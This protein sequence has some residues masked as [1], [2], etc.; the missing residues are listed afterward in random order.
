MNK[1]YHTPGVIAMHPPACLCIKRICCTIHDMKHF[2][3]K[4]FPVLLGLLLAAAGCT[5]LQNEKT[6]YSAPSPKVADS[7]LLV[8]VTEVTAVP[9]PGNTSVPVNTPT[10]AETA[11]PTDTPVPGW[12]PEDIPQTGEMQLVVYIGS[13]S[14]CAYEEQNGNWQLVRI[15]ACSTGR[16][17][18]TPAGS[19]RISDTYV[20]HSLY[21]AKGQYCSR[22]RGHYLFHSVPIDE[23]ARKITQ[24]R[25][26][27]KLEEYEKLG[28]AA[29]DGCVRLCCGDAKWIFDH[30]GKGTAV[31]VT[32]EKGP[33]PPALPA[34]IPGAPYETEPGYG[35]DP[36]D[37]DPE[38]PY[39]EVYGAYE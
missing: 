20:Y 19:F 17:D 36:T 11:V 33:E 4:I 5:P 3:Q 7:P 39:L 10:P 21:G 12:F 29:S 30:C 37:P 27:M 25:G 14:V 9:V 38:N 15:M 13:Q 8:Q 2:L 26:R 31:V 1:S 34:L 24:G 28:T 16:E 35:W 6:V 23:N 22:F 32:R 18:G